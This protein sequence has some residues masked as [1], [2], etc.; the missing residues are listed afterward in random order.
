[1]AQFV[2]IGT[3]ADFADLKGGR[4]VEVGGHS[5]AVFEVDGGYCAIENSCPHAGGPLSEGELI[6]E[7]VTCPWHGSR[8]NV[9]SGAVLSPPAT[10][11]V[12]TFPARITGND[13]EVQIG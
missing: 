10:R 1:M 8:F 4:L 5:L 13:V 7:V 6:G 3:Q 9:K 12:K 2:R 11:G